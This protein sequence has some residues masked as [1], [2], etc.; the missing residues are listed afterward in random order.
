M[1]DNWYRI[2]WIFK[3]GFIKSDSGSIQCVQNKNKMLMESLRKRDKFPMS[4]KGVHPRRS[5]TQETMT[6]A[7]GYVQW[8]RDHDDC[9]WLM[10]GPGSEDSMLD[11]LITNIVWT[12][13]VLFVGFKVL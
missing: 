3:V 1:A 13:L 4:Y 8:Q 12:I 11:S 2:D 6:F 5:S 9:S 7:R 10:S